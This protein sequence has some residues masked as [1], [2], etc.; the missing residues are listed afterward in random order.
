LELITIRA[1]EKVDT[2]GGLWDKLKSVLTFIKDNVSKPDFT[3]KDPG[4]SN[5]DVI[6]S[7]EQWQRDELSR[8]MGR[9]IQRIEDNPE[10]IKT[11]FPVNDDFADDSNSSNSYGIKGPTVAPSIPSNNQ[12]FG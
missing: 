9:I 1:F 7:L 5:N 12:R 4:N 8:T 11:Y 2:K 3:L 10:N 6:S